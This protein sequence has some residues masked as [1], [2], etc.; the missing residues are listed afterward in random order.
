MS[1]KL[2]SMLAKLTVA[3]MA[4]SICYV[5][6]TPTLNAYA[7]TT[8]SKVTASSSTTKASSVVTA[9][10]FD[11]L[12][13]AASSAVSGQ[14]IEIAANK[15]DCTSQLV[16]DKVDSG[17]TIKAAAGYSPVLDFSSFRTKAQAESPKATGDKYA[18][19][20]ITGGS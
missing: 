12:K 16:L 2:K 5:S 20:R 4:L 7:A 10:T 18:G 13:A 11:E 8:S 1:K 19:I 6:G 17:I 3:S 15:L 14:T 9:K